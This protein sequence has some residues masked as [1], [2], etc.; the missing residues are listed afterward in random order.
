MNNLVLKIHIRTAGIKKLIFVMV[1][2]LLL[3]IVLCCGY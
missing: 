3:Q 2:M 1:I